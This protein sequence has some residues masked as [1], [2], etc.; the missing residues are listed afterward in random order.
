MPSAII[1]DHAGSLDFTGGDGQAQHT[2]TL[3]SKTAVQA[4]IFVSRYNWED[5]ANAVNIPGELPERVVVGSWVQ[6]A[7]TSVTKNGQVIN[8]DIENAPAT[9]YGTG[10]SSLT[11]TIS[12]GTQCRATAAWVVYIWG[13]VA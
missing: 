8:Y 9:Y 11:F 10:I 3:D 2:L 6:V 7:I 4:F 13:E 5:I 1:G 12:A